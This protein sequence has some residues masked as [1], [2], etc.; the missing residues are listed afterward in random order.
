MNL[1]DD[2]MSEI[3]RLLDKIHG[4]VLQ[5]YPNGDWR[6]SKLR[7]I[8]APDP[9]LTCHMKAKMWFKNLEE[10][11]YV[12]S[13]E[14]IDLF[15]DILRDMANL[16]KVADFSDE[17]EGL[18][19][20]GRMYWIDAKGQTR[21]PAPY[22][23]LLKDIK[24]YCAKLEDISNQLINLPNQST[25]TDPNIVIVK[26]SIRIVKALFHE[27]TLVNLEASLSFLGIIAHLCNVANDFRE[28]EDQI[29]SRIRELQ[30]S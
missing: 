8:G 30:N 24:N 2:Y 6:Q 21:T 14:H 9:D 4:C 19:E 15:F 23:F 20:L 10:L 29:E 3:K 11:L 28:D 16:C 7:Q 25:L 17:I 1:C 22:E 13:P 27:P 18:R 26:K 12:P 5:E